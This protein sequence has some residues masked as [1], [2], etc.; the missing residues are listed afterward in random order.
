MLTSMTVLTHTSLKTI[1]SHK[2]YE[3]SKNTQNKNRMIK[4]YDKVEQTSDEWHS[5]REQYPLTGSTS[6]EF[7]LCRDPATY[8]LKENNFTG[9]KWTQ[10]GHDLEG[11]ARELL[12]RVTG[13]LV[14][15]TGFVTNTAYPFAGCSP[16]GFTDEHL[17]EI[18]CFSKER[19]LANAKTTDAKITSQVQWNML[20][21][22]K[23]LG[24][25]VF[26]CPDTSLKPEEQLIIKE[27]EPNER[28]QTNMKNRIEIYGRAHHV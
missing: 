28:I 17:V 20:I 2:L 22:E 21:M 8:V 3:Q 18:K 5:L 26:F 10:R 4:Y 1:I 12:T 27:V 25:L 13:L 7:L 6:Y 15:E 16:D 24:I 23:P 11:V 19:H 9:N 14:K